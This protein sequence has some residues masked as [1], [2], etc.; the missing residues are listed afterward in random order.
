MSS[1]MRCLRVRTLCACLWLLG[2]ALPSGAA[3]PKVAE[4]GER[5]LL[6]ADGSASVSL[7]LTV[8]ALG[9]NGIRIPVRH[10]SLHSL[11]AQGPG[12]VGARVREEN[13]LRFIQLAIPAV[14]PRP[15]TLRVSYE[16]KDYT[17][18]GAGLRS[19][20]YRFQNL[21]FDRIRSFRAI[22]ALPE[23]YIVQAVG[24]FLPKPAKAGAP[25]PYAL[26]RE[27]GR[28]GVRMGTTD[29][30]LGDEIALQATF[31]HS[32]RSKPLFLVLL[33]AALAY[34]VFYRDILKNPRKGGG[35]EG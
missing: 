9:A 21:T 26:F 11:D 10:A 13:G 24:E 35:A 12:P 2:A 25:P 19:L 29:V 22:L 17:G 3:G 7:S 33:A 4:Y 23:G 34:L 1:R 8:A 14:A 32:R 28:R 5:V 30:G 16:V 20:D 15:L 27:G 18:G 31:R 6:R